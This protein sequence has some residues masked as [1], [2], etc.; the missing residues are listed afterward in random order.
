MPKNRGR[1]PGNFSL[2]IE[3]PH[4]VS[5][6]FVF[7]QDLSHELPLGEIGMLP[8]YVFT[9][10]MHPKLQALVHSVFH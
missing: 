10:D 5:A 8:L 2:S 7:T 3:T 1:F 4:G 9:G 6:S